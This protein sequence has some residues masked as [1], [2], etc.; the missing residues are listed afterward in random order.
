MRFLEFFKRQFL[1]A[2]IWGIPVRID[3][4]W[5]L[6]V[7]VLTWVS[8]NSIP[9]SLLENYTAKIGFGLSAI[10]VFFFTVFLHELAHA[11]VARKEGIHVIEIL[12]HPF[13]G[14]AKLRKEPPTPRSEFR[15]AIA[16]PIASFRYRTLFSWFIC[17]FNSH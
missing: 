8:A 12:L 10:L 13:G 3:Y 7:A 14:L 11:Y 4:S 2:H 5:F 16:G 9:N 6:V 17:A 15:I 1:I